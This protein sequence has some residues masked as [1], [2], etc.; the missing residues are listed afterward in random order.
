MKKLTVLLA[1]LALA[2][3]APVFAQEEAT[4][5]F[6]AG[7]TSMEYDFNH[8]VED[9]GA[10]ATSEYFD[11][12]LDAKFTA[13]AGE[14]EVWF[15]IE[16]SDGTAGGDL[17]PQ[18]SWADA[19][20]GY[21]GKWTPESMAD[22]GFFLQVGDLGTGFGKNVNNDDS[23][24]GSIE[25]GFT[26]GNMSG[27]LGYGRDYEGF[28]NDDVEGDGHLA[29][30]QVNMSLGE[31]GF[32]LG[33]YTALY[34][35][36]D[37][38]LQGYAEVEDV[39][40]TTG[41][42]DLIVT[43]EVTGGYN[44]FL[45]SVNLSGAAGGADI[46]AEVGFASGTI[47]V[48]DEVNN[49]SAEDDV[50]GFYALG[51]ASIAMGSLTLGVEGGFGSGDDPGTANENEGF[52]A[53]NNDFGFD[54]I[55]EDEILGDGLSNKIYAKLSVGASPSEKVSVDGAVSYVAPVEDVAGANGTVDAYGFEVNGTM[56]YKLSDSLT[57][58]LMGAFASLEED[59]TGE[60][61]AFQMQNALTFSF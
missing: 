36:S 42:V 46:F 39:D 13:S 56:K 57:Y 16:V 58:K 24:W 5:P 9:A 3:A 51:G 35:A 20:G 25:T 8:F 32:S 18:A 40:Y 49:V 34:A 6:L 43:P 54:E 27:V 7:V 37:L 15:E 11:D 48:T 28:S 14:I 1:C 31:S 4:S 2:L 30:G 60:S 53:F 45:G 61:S 29:R 44:V 33:A 55:I 17:A 50:S 10:G 22:N 47:D 19:V 59:W 26:M 52:L 12:D 21:G 38:I 23:P 41:T